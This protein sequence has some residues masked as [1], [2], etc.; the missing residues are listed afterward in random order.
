MAAKVK[1]IKFTQ[2]RGAAEIRLIVIKTNCEDQFEI[3][4]G[5]VFF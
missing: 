2:S 5:K 1:Q 3:I 4:G